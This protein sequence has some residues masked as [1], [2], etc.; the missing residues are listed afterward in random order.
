M[1]LYGA[2]IWWGSMTKVWAKI[3]LAQTQRLASLMITDAMRT[4]PTAAMEI[5]VVVTLFYLSVME[6]ARSSFRRRLSFG[7]WKNTNLQYGA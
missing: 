1:I 5:Q 2:V 7:Q 6:T 3:I 4:T